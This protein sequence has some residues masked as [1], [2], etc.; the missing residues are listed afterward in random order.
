MN[1]KSLADRMNRLSGRAGVDLGGLNNLRR[2][3]ATQAVASG[4][5]ITVAQRQFGHSDPRTTAAHLRA[6]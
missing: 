4:L 5:L 1:T 3:T 6:E 2:W